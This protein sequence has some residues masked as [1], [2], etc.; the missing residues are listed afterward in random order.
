MEKNFTNGK[1]IL[2]MALLG[3]SLFSLNANAGYIEDSGYQGTPFNGPHIIHVPNFNEGEET[4]PSTTIQ[5][6][7]FDEG[8]PDISF[9]FKNADAGNYKDYRDEKR[10]AIS[11]PNDDVINVGNIEDGDWL[12]YTIEV[13]DSADFTLDA[14]CSADGAPG[15]MIF[16]VDDKQIT[17]IVKSATAGWDNY[18]PTRA[19]GIHLDKGTHVFKVKKVGF[20]LNWDKFVFNYAGDYNTTY[21]YY[22]PIPGTVQAEWYDEQLDE[23]LPTYSFAQIGAGD[24]GNFRLAGPDKNLGISGSDTDDNY[25][26]IGNTTAGDWWQYTVDCQE[27]R[28]DYVVTAYIASAADDAGFTMD[29]D[30]TQITSSNVACNTG[31]WDKHDIKPFVAAENVSI[32]EGEH[33][34]TFH[35][36]G[37]LN[38]D[39][40]TVTYPGYDPTGIKDI[41]NDVQKK[42]DNYYYSLSGVRSVKPMKGINIHNGKKIIV[43]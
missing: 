7:D 21:E 3:M 29:L 28:D 4:A 39:R 27:S 12:C 43:K 16:Y 37:G 31:G 18:L 33:T 40:F 10:V 13:E 38:F 1:A 41:K 9:H 30:Y 14:Y 19:Y 26:R 17:G 6:E 36:V 2:T 34:F 23:D 20:G 22:K 24:Q 11:R 8:G 15:T 42:S 25:V 32:S 5:A 35:V